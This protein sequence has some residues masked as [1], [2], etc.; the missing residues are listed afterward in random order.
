MGKITPPA[1]IAAEHTF[2]NF[3]C[4]VESLNEWIRKYAVRNEASGASRTFVVCQG[5]E[6][7]GYYALATGSITHQQAPG[8]IKRQMPDPIPVMILGRLAVDKLW[9]SSGIG[10]GL[11]KDALLRTL[12]VS[13]Q[14]GV[15]ALLVHALSDEAKAFYLHHGF[16]ESPI[17]P[18]ALM[19]SLQDAQKHYRESVGR[20]PS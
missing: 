4:G 11:L 1:P 13:H 16:L 9:Q 20:Y 17:D 7:V 10:R 12:A 15:R 5:N 3:D 2:A 8:K 14:V 6:V 18:F 19:L